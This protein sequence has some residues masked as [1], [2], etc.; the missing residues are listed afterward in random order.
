MPKLKNFLQDLGSAVVPAAISAGATYAS[1]GT[2]NPATTPG[3]LKLL[4]TVGSGARGFAGN[5]A[6]ERRRKQM[7]RQA[8]EDRRAQGMANLINALQPGTGARARPAEIAAPK[9][10]LGETLARGT[11]TGIDAF[12]MAKQAEEAWKDRELARQRAQ[13]VIDAAE[14]EKRVG[15]KPVRGPIGT[16]GTR[17]GATDVPSGLYKTITNVA[18]YA[19][20]RYELPQGTNLPISETDT[21]YGDIPVSGTWMKAKGEGQEEV[22]G[23]GTIPLGGITTEQFFAQPHLAAAYGEGKTKRAE[24][25]LKRATTGALKQKERYQT[26]IDNVGNI[27]AYNNVAQDDVIDESLKMFKH[28]G[29]GDAEDFKSI[30]G[31]IVPSWRAARQQRADVTGEILDNVLPLA[32]NAYDGTNVDEAVALFLSQAHQ[33]NIKLTESEAEIAAKAILAQ[34]KGL[35]L[36]EENKKLFAGYTYIDAS[37][38]SIQD[39]FRSILPDKSTLKDGKYALT[40]SGEAYNEA[41]YNEFSEAFG[42]LKGRIEDL[43]AEVGKAV[44]DDDT[45]EAL[46]RIGF[47]VEFAG[48]VFSGAQVRPDEHDLLRNIFIGGFTSTPERTLVDT[49]LFRKQLKNM[50]L[51]LASVGMGARTGNVY[52]YLPNEH[53]V[54]L[55]ELDDPI[56]RVELGRR[57]EHLEIKLG[58]S[59]TPEDLEEF[60]WGSIAGSTAYDDMIKRM[61]E[62]TNLADFITPGR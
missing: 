31:S 8:E 10:G 36:S 2:L 40:L 22:V 55:L 33:Q 62:Y 13:Q 3:L 25:E 32:N 52:G 4:A 50:R 35:D 56:A 46:T 27:L 14:L 12:T 53:L 16:L 19:P 34:A 61:Q 60:A 58:R 11:A 43:K 41:R 51:A 49:D 21:L 48:R 20:D 37:L 18:Q 24:R 39:H 38:V 30:S 9:A 5:E 26:F 23:P 1:G 59:P 44:M 29:L 17:G 45:A 6:E 54:R 42:A 28:L 57:R 47:A 15:A 7:R